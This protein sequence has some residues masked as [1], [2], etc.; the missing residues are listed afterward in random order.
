MTQSVTPSYLHTVAD[1]LNA[2]KPLAPLAQE[3]APAKDLKP[4]VEQALKILNELVL[5]PKNYQHSLTKIKA[6]MDQLNT[7]LEAANKL[8][9]VHDCVKIVYSIEAQVDRIA[10]NVFNETYPQST[11]LRRLSVSPPIPATS[12]DGD[13]EIDDTD[14]EVV[15]MC[16]RSVSVSFGANSDSESESEPDEKSRASGIVNPFAVRSD[17]CFEVFSEHT[18]LERL[19]LQINEQIGLVVS[20]IKQETA[21]T[22]EKKKSFNYMVSFVKRQSILLSECDEKSANASPDRLQTL[23]LAGQCSLLGKCIKDLKNIELRIQNYKRIT[24]GLPKNQAEAARMELQQAFDTALYLMDDGDSDEEDSKITVAN[25]SVEVSSDSDTDPLSGSPT[26]APTAVA[27][28]VEEELKLSKEDCFKALELSSELDLELMSELISFLHHQKLSEHKLGHLGEKLSSVSRQKLFK[29]LMELEESQK[30]QFS[31]NEVISDE[32]T[33]NEK[34]LDLSILKCL[35]FKTAVVRLL[36]SQERRVEFSIAYLARIKKI[37]SDIVQ[38]MQEK[39]TSFVEERLSIH[40]YNLVPLSNRTRTR[41][42]KFFER[43]CEGKKVDV[44]KL[45]EDYLKGYVLFPPSL[46]AITKTIEVTSADREGKIEF[47]FVKED[48]DPNVRGSRLKEVF[49]GNDPDRLKMMWLNKEPVEESHSKPNEEHA[50]SSFSECHRDWEVLIKGFEAFA[51]E[52]IKGSKTVHN[53]VGQF[54]RLGILK[55]LIEDMLNAFEP[56]EPPA[57]VLTPTTPLELS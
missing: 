31:L 22:S 56:Q 35:E 30:K 39:N 3:K 5:I 25:F 12:T 21:S 15:S 13:S 17:V 50:K 18:A 9:K 44:N 53:I 1:L 7:E 32:F 40:E 27:P 46:K 52:N 8:A 28:H 24:S 43:V 54:V 2:C 37:Q 34:V 47:A 38:A 51:A 33:Q 14:S 42:K 6:E 23:N 36:N 19:G 16:S 29:A 49:V 20:Q 41:L 26:A 48:T 45:F 4:L 11:H 57:I 10:E 55:S